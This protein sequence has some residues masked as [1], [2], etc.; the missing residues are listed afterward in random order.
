MHSAA[1][2]QEAT[3][4][5]VNDGFK[6]LELQLRAIVSHQ[7]E[8]L[9]IADNDRRCLAA[10][11]GAR[12]L[13]GLSM[14]KIIGQR[15]ADL[16]APSKL[17]LTTRSD[18]LPGLHVVALHDNSAGNEKPAAGADYAFLSFDNDGIVVEWNSGAERVYGYKR[19][20]I[21][22][23]HVSRLCSD[24]GVRLNSHAEG[25]HKKKDESRFW[26]NALTTVVRDERG[27]P[28]GF[29]RLVRDFSTRHRT[30]EA[31]LHKRAG[32]QHPPAE[33]TIAGI[34]SGE[35]DRIIDANDAFLNGGIQPRGFSRRAAAVG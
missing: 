31:L 32:P 29:A 24:D 14:S 22:G 34:V 27:E 18:V 4:W 15:L 23:Q 3:G 17:H 2:T 20:E 30:D 28:R 16:A 5:L 6:E 35:F 10:S 33:S 1:S 11:P 8:P 21:L 9:L 13:L 26:A 25:W 7:S 12:K 19:E